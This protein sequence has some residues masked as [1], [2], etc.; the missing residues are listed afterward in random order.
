MS[1][2]IATTGD[3]HAFAAEAGRFLRAE[4]AREQ[5]ARI[6]D[7]VLD[8]RY[9]E[10]PNHF[11][12]V[13]GDDG[14]LVAAA[15][16]TPP[17]N[18][19]C[20]RL[21]DPVSLAAAL[22]DAWVAR[23]PDLVGVVAVPDTARALA[24]AWAR[25]TGGETRLHVSM[26]MH[27]AQA[28][29]DPARPVAGRLRLAGPDDRELLVPWWRGF[30]VEAEPL[31]A[32]DAQ[33]AVAARVADRGLYVWEDAGA[34]VSLIGARL[35]GG[36]IGWI[37]PVYTPPSLRR[38]GYAGAGVAASSRRLLDAGASLCMLFTD[39]A[40]PTSNKVYHEVGYRRLADWED[41]RFTPR[42]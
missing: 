16:R 1:Y 24:A 28:I 6:L 42:R 36:G 39:L 27:A 14:L 33:E 38:R 15:L 35:T 17:H 34:P 40:N 2:A 3:A 18:L 22:I 26:A 20:T 30:Y 8:G 11:A 41:H 4:P 23:D 29:E 12:T 21:P 5:L 37:G 9:V 19:N 13:R 10:Y 31:H 25:R 32:D 7:G